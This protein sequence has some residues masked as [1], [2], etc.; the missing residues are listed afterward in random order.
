ME[1]CSNPE[2]HLLRHFTA[3]ARQ[4]QTVVGPHPCLTPCV[5]LTVPNLVLLCIACCALPF[6]DPQAT[7]TIIVI[8]ITVTHCQSLGG[9]VPLSPTPS[10]N[11][12]PVLPS[13]RSRLGCQ[14]ILTDEL[15]G[16]RVKLPF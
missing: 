13:P 10:L 6:P 12:W 14:V 7:I 1:G 9:I 11:P 15:N 8:T 5:N 3:P 16:M 4:R 2:H